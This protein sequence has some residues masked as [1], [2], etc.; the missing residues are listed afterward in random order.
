V[1]VPDIEIATNITHQTQVF[2][3]MMVSR[4]PAL[5]VIRDRNV[6]L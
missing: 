2:W 3:F 6:P 1:A 5:D 4:V